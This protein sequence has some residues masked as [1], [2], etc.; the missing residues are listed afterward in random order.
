MDYLINEGYP[1]AAKRFA[2]EANIKG[3][4]GDTDTIQERVEIRNAILSGDAESAIHRVNDLDPEV[5]MSKP[6]FHLEPDTQCN[7]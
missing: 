3:T 5:S 6:C 2:A 4:P 1:D 7:D